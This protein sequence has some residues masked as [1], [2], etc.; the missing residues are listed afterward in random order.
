MGDILHLLLRLGLNSLHQFSK[1]EEGTDCSRGRLEGRF[2]TFIPHKSMFW[3][4]N[5]H[6]LRTRYRF[7]GLSLALFLLDIEIHQDMENAT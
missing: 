2:L 7:P 3:L 5:A 4:Y 1:R 6:N